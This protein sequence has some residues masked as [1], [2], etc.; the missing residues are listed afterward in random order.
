MTANPDATPPARTT[1]AASEREL[2]NAAR[3][4]D[5]EAFGR[6][7][8]PYR[9]ELLAHCY[10]MLGSHAD[11]EDALQE[12]LLGAWRGLARSSGEARFAPGCT[13]SRPTPA[14][15]RSSD[16]PSGYCQSTTRP[17]PTHATD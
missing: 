11:A 17:Q 10:R 4:D 6:L 7:V 2:L 8:E 5:R 12:T 9:R 1:R 16:G 13:G 14:C 3:N 15:A